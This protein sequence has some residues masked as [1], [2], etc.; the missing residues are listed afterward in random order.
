LDFAKLDGVFK[1]KNFV[2]VS[3]FHSI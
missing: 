1:F 2:Q 3:N